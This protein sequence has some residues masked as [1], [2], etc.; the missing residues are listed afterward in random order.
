MTIEQGIHGGD[1]IDD[2][3]FGM[4]HHP[5]VII[6]SPSQFDFYSGGGLDIAF[7]GMA[8]MDGEGNVN[9]SRLNGNVNG[10]GGF[11]DISQNA[12]QVVFCGTFD[13]KDGR[14]RKLVKAVAHITFS[15]QQ[16]RKRGQRVLYVTERATFEL[17]AEGL[18]L[19]DVAPGVDVRRDVLDRMDFQ[20]IV[21]DVGTYPAEVMQ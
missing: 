18:K 15:G 4:A 12:K 11:I 20:P 14:I 17:T 3:L 19:V 6:D 8:E 7:L 13:A 9:V 16:A 5:D 1:M 10:P 2:D 21:G